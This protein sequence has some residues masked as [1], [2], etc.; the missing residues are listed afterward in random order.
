MQRI[1]PR[2]HRTAWQK[3]QQQPMGMC[4][5]YLLVALALFVSLS[6]FFSP[7]R[8]D[9]IHLIAKNHPP[10]LR[11]WFGTDDLGR[12]VLIRTSYGAYISLCI[13]LA[14]VIIDLILGF[15][16]GSLAA[17]SGKKT[18]ECLMR[19]LDIFYSIPTLLIAILLSVIL[20]SGFFSIVLA[21]NLISWITMARIVRGQLLLLKEMDFVMASRSLGASS[22]RILFTHLLPNTWGPIMLTL[23][24]TIPSAIFSEAFLSFLGLGIQAPMASWGTMAHEGLAAFQ[25]YPWRLFFPAA[26]ISITMLA[27][28]L[29]GEGLKKSFNNAPAMNLP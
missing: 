21:I 19:F 26:F 17:L 25:Y 15:L 28:Y 7:F 5:I 18:G 20:G 11:F 13:A 6:G 24:M 27:F 2:L 8:Y 4:G 29:I 12:D 22:S 23:T 1:V 16:I 3:F 9:E 14:T 10:S